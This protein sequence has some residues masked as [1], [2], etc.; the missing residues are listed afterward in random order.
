MMRKATILIIEEHPIVAEMMQ[1]Y[2]MRH[3]PLS[4]VIVVETDEDALVYLKREPVHLVITHLHDHAGQDGFAFLAML[5]GWNPPI[6]IIAISDQ[7][8]EN[9]RSVAGGVAILH[10]PV[11]F[12][13]L[14]ELID[15]MTL[16]SQESVLN[17]VS[18]ESFLQM[19]EQD[20]KT[21]TLRIISGYQ[22]GYL[23]LGRGRLIGAKTGQLEDKEAALAIL[24][25]PNCTI[26]ISESSRVEP[27]MDMAIHSLV[28]EWCLFKDIRDASG[29][30]LE[31]V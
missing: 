9:S 19:L 29:S 11:D 17:G 22:T 24:G 4:R 15:T 13:V 12:D 23:H 20:H 8:S 26:N 18:L 1:G 28:M 5:N 16:A 14:L 25:W 10:N 30:S 3:K 21:C 6:P 2:I 7:S 31:A 27:T